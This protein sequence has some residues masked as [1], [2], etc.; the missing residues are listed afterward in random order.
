MQRRELAVGVPPL[1]GQRREPRDFGGV[2]A[3]AR[4]GGDGHRAVLNE[5][6]PPVNATALVVR[7]SPRR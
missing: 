3:G 2:D 1:A 6:R 4:G 5:L 7:I